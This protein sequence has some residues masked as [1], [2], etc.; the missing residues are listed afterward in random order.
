MTWFKRLN[1]DLSFKLACG[2]VSSE[3]SYNRHH[4]KLNETDVLEKVQETTVLD[5]ISE[6]FIP[7]DTVSF[8]ATHL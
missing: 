3:A 5:M 4:T 7:D 2:F 1:H 6:E 8:D